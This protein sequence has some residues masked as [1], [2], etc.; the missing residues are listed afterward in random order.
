MRSLGLAGIDLKL[1]S[2]TTVCGSTR[3]VSVNQYGNLLKDKEV[4]VKDSIT[5]SDSTSQILDSQ[6]IQGT[7]RVGR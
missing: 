4:I 2:V 1:C 6:A 5:M 7:S 3:L